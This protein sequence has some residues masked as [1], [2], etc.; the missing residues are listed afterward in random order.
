MKTSEYLDLAKKTH[1]MRSDNELARILEWSKSQ[2]NNYRH[3]R[4][5]MDNEAARKYAEFIDIPVW[6][7][8]ADMEA[9]RQKDPVKK[10]AWKML[11]KSST[12]KGVALPKQLILNAFIFWGAAYCIL[13]KIALQAKR[14]SADVSPN[15][16]IM[17]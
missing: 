14:H 8:I 1:G 5:Q 12:Q 16:L 15:Y 7:V 13:C 4:Q 9:Q 17:A 6:Q 10:Q 3:N 2:V 11:S